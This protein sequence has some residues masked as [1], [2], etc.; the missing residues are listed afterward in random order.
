MASS[1]PAGSTTTTTTAE[2]SSVVRPY[3]AGAMGQAEALFK[4]GMLSPSYYPGA[5]IADE[6]PY[7]RAARGMIVNRAIGGSPV[8]RSAAGLLTGTLRGDY[9]SP[10][11]N[12]GFQQALADTARAYSTG[13]AAQRDAAAN[14]NRSYGGS[15]W[16]EVKAAQDKSF[17]DS[18]NT[19][20]GN[21]YEGERGR[22]MQGL[23]FAPQM[24]NQD[25][26]DAQQLA[27]VGSSEE[28]RSQDVINADINRY[29]YNAQ[30][31]YNA[32]SSYL[33]LLNQ[34]GGKSQTETQPYYTNRGAGALGGA[35]TGAGIG[36]SYGPF[37]TLI[38][39]GLGLLGGQF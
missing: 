14:M 27:E 12:P 35:L 7:T 13:T 24:A 8:N 28:G 34:Y 32:L 18:L 39:G 31:P 5:T 9:L 21:L 22:Q 19:I 1:K 20:A 37:G 38:G 16:Q 36:S 23:L 11:N 17:A 2:P 3:L 6:S 33:G 30:L 26:F 29:N 10:T 25:Y 15:A 4:G